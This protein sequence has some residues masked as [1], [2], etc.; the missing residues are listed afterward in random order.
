[1]Y[2]IPS[3]SAKDCVFCGKKFE[4]GSKATCAVKCKV[5][6]TDFEAKFRGYEEHGGTHIGQCSI[7][8]FEYHEHAGTYE[9]PKVGICYKGPHS[10]S[11]ADLK[12]HRLKT[13][14]ESA[15]K[16]NFGDGEEE[17]G[18]EEEDLDED[19]EDGEEDEDLESSSD[20]DSS[21]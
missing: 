4:A 10:S 14:G 12:A 6:W 18:E 8:G 9:E 1:M 16:V 11:A 3:S 17:D 13:I 21:S 7:C 5:D 20:V 15:Y 19:V 2:P